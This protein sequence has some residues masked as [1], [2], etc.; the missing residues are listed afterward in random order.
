MRAGRGV[1]TRV[2]PLCERREEAGTHREGS[3]AEVTV[4]MV[5]Q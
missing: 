2:P 5:E 3:G 1:D 4:A